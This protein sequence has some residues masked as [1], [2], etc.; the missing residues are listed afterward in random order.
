[1]A[2]NLAHPNIVT[3]HQ[4]GKHKKLLYTVLL[5]THD[6]DEALHLSDRILLM[7]DGPRSTVGLELSLD[8]P[9]PRQRL[10]GPSTP[11]Y[12]RQR[13]TILSFLESHS[14][15]FIERESC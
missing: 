2:G 6:V 1:M 15:K 9:R 8:F 7:T 3:I 14:K 5:V 10:A 13:A 4:I 12:Q 11:E